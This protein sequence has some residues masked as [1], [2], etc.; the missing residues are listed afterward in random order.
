MRNLSLI[1]T[2]AILTQFP[3]VSALQADGIIHNLPQ[4]GSW[5]EYFVEG[6][7]TDANDP[8][9]V[10]GGTGKLK[11]SS[12]GTEAVD[13]EPCRWLEIQGSLKDDNRTQ[14]ERFVLKLLIPEKHLKKGENP[15]ERILRG[16]ERVSLG[17]GDGDAV[18]LDTA[19]PGHLA[20]VLDILLAGPGTK[21]KQV[22]PKTIRF[23]KGAI[24]CPGVTASFSYPMKVRDEV[25]KMPGIVTTRF[26]ETVPFGV[27]ALEIDTKEPN[28][29]LIEINVTLN[30]YGDG[31]KTQLPDHR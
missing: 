4:D 6:K 12:V 31:A 16:W 24:E 3:A 25:R 7:E 29:D 17:D 2:T 13:G 15:R 27:A 26:H 1:L 14:E 22:E 21:T 20:W 30:D 18:K 10:K 8:K 23:Q 28:G 5:V 19:D 11:I 9:D